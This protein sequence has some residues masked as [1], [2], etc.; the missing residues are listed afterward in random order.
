MRRFE[1]AAN[2]ERLLIPW[3]DLS[4][5]DGTRWGLYMNL[6]AFPSRASNFD[7]LGVSSC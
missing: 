1:T 4:L 2:A 3:S 6:L 5:S 7:S